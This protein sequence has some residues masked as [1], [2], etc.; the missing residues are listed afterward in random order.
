MPDQISV[1]V[2]N[3]LSIA[4]NPELSLAS[5]T[6]KFLSN[7]ESE[8][9]DGITVV[10]AMRKIADRAFPNGPTDP[11]DFELLV[12]AF[13]NSSLY[14]E[15][16]T[17]LAENLESD[18]ISTIAA[19]RRL[20][21]F[22]KTVRETAKSHILEVIMQ[23]S[24]AVHVEENVVDDFVETI[25]TTFSGRI[26][27]GNLNYDSLLAAALVHRFSG[28]L[29]DMADGRKDA[30]MFVSNSK[31]S[32]KA[33]RLRKSVDE[34]MYSRLLLL[35]LHGSLAFW[36]A[37]DNSYHIKVPVDL[38]TDLDQWSSIR[39]QSASAYP[40]VALT[41]PSEK[42]NT[43]E[44][45]PFNIAYDLFK[46]SLSFSS[47]WIIV[48]YS[49]RDSS[50]NAVLQDKFSNRADRPRVLVID[51]GDDLKR[52]IVCEAFG[53]D[54]DQMGD[55]ESWLTISRDGVENFRN[56]DEWAGFVRT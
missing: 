5:I 37:E 39:T 24:R 1:L 55:A 43:V 6:K 42:L 3:G 51:R 17:L 41:G 47:K 15:E 38:L 13:E 12:G 49:F 40:L 35:H 31:T 21:A 14:L 16:L 10:A 28:E 45:F 7:L 56:S 36:A 18:S 20:A 52:E 48:G 8:S 50:I 29:V 19:L 34:Y 9:F 4:F 53:W 44:N 30:Q 2:G 25:C 11:H 54:S 26:V 46:T 33:A 27:F 32:G 23:N 22:A